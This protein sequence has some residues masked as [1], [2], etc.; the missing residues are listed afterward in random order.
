RVIDVRSARDHAEY[1]IPSS[2]QLAL[3]ELTRMPLKPAETVVLYSEGG[4]HAAQGWFLLRARGIEHVYFLRGGLYEWLTQ[5][6]DL[7]LPADGRAEEGKTVTEV[8]ELSRYFGGQ[9]RVS[10]QNRSEL[11]AAVLAA[12]NSS[13]ATA[14]VIRRVKRRGC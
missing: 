9:P 6:V 5:V 4:T 8:A 12:S 14:D 11:E 2:E 3:V 10:S 7:T 13:S 1:N